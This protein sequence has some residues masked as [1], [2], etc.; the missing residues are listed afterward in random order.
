MDVENADLAAT[1]RR[2]TSEPKQ[3]ATLLGLPAVWVVLAAIVLAGLIALWCL[4]SDMWTQTGLG[5]AFWAM[6]VIPVV[7]LLLAAVLV[8]SLV[9]SRFQFGPRSL[10]VAFT[11]VGVGLGWLIALW[12]LRS[13]MWKQTGLGVAFWAAVV[14]PVVTL[15][16]A[17]VLVTSLVRS[18]FQFGLRSLLIAFTIAGLGLG[19][20]GM[21][22][23]RTRQQRACVA[24]LVAAGAVVSYSG[25]KNR[26]G[27]VRFLGPEYFYHVF[28]VDWNCRGGG[29]PDLTYLH[30]LERLSDLSLF[31]TN[32]GD[33]DLADLEPLSNLW[34]L[35]LVRTNISRDGLAPLQRLPGLR[36]LTLADCRLEDGAL[37]P[38]SRLTPLKG[39][40]LHRSSVGDQELRDL[41]GLTSLAQLGLWDTKITN[42]GLVHLQHLTQLKRLELRDTQITA[43][44]LEHLTVLKSLRGLGLGGTQVTDA[45]M[46]HI[47]AL[48]SLE[49]L[50]L[51]D[52]SVGDAGLKRLV[53][54]TKLRKLQLVQ[55][56]VTDEGV[57]QLREKLPNCRVVH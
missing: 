56:Q 3:R 16:L 10:W 41:K 2:G 27:L 20:L 15:L 57:R 29:P 55:T 6:V 24:K 23:N 39:L 25:P 49:W 40:D 28:H 5:V 48:T 26:P 12:C 36:L 22:L 8:T 19:W 21:F 31:E 13:D 34:N 9:R 4:R 46:Q 44:G 32:I 54:L 1:E 30:G 33:G 7:T 38:L 17:A 50:E 53:A 47:A 51:D 35:S 18:R 43:A 11:I 45:D 42:D 37:A 14:I 52:T